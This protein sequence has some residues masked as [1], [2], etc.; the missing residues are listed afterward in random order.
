MPGRRNHA[1]THNEALAEYRLHEQIERGEKVSGPEAGWLDRRGPAAHAGDS[2]DALTR[3]V[4][5]R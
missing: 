2:S 4:R 1:R 3:H 5:R